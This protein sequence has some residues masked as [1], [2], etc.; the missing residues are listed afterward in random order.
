MTDIMGAI[1]LKQYERY[2]QMLERRKQIIEKYDAAFKPLGVE[3]LPHYTKDHISSG[4]LYIARI[5]NC[6]DQKRR[7]IIIKLAE[8]GISTNV[9]YKPLPMHTAY[10]KLGFDIKNYP[11]AYNRYANE[12]TL[13]LHT[14][15]TDEEVDYII[16]TVTQVLKDYAN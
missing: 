9:H 4:H 10:K 13:P 15:L 6:D 8:L 1:G 16:K 5:P 7:E 3:V 2:P 14:C 12:I 11:N